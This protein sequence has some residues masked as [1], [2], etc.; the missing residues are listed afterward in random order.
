VK[1]WTAH[2]KPRLPPVLVREGFSFGALMFGAIWLAVHRAWIQ[3]AA[4]LLLAVLILVLA[5]P[6]ASLILITGLALLLGMSG[7]DLVRWS[8]T[9]NGYAQTGVVTGANEDEAHARLLIA[10]PDLVEQSMVAEAMP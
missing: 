4:S 8:L 10:R 9:L 1:I 5:G 6:P 7:N 2:E 3:A